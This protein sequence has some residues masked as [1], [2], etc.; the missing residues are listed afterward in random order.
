MGL[1][2]GVDFHGV[3][4]NR[5]GFQGV[6]QNFL[7]SETQRLQDQEQQRIMKLASNLV[8]GAASFR[9][10]SASQGVTGQASN[11][12]GKQQRDAAMGKALDTGLSE[13]ERSSA[14]LNSQYLSLTG[15]NEAMKLDSEKFNAEGNF[16]ADQ[17]NNKQLTDFASGI[18]SNVLT[19]GTGILATKMGMESYKSIFGGNT[20][21]DLSMEEGSPG[22]GMSD[23]NP[24]LGGN[25]FSTKSIMD[26]AKEMGNI[27][28]PTSEDYFKRLFQPQ[29]TFGG[30]H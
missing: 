9:A 13:S 25:F 3:D 18:F 4:T 2:S 6:Y 10:Q 26:R 14:N 5:Y 29:F 21:K 1:F 11:V 8:P 20:G 17:Y 30:G 7:K 23:V 16:Q 19:A 22:F 28:Q 12:I 15:H 27:T 24:K